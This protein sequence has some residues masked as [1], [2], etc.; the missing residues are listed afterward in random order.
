MIIKHD[1]KYYNEYALMKEHKINTKK[2][3]QNAKMSGNGIY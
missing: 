1:P 3:L 2:F